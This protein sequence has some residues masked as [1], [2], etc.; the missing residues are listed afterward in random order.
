MSINFKL[1][2]K[3]YNNQINLILAEDGLT[4]RCLLNYG[5]TNKNFCPNCVFDIGLKKSANKYKNNGP[6]FFSEGMICPYCNG[7]GFYGKQNSDQIYLAVLWDYKSWMSPPTNIAYPEGYVQT[8]CH[9]SNVFKIRR[10][11]DITIVLDDNISNP[12]FQLHEEPTP[13]GLGDNNY[14]FCMWKKIGVSS[15]LSKIPQ[16]TQPPEKCYSS[17]EKL[18]LLCNFANLCS[19]AIFDIKLNKDLDF[20]CVSTE[21]FGFDLLCDEINKCFSESKSKELFCSYI[22]KCFSDSSDLALVCN[23][24]N[25]CLSEDSFFIDG[26][27]QGIEN[28]VSENMNK[29]HL[30][31]KNGCS[32]QIQN[33]QLSNNIGCLSNIDKLKLLDN[34]AQKC[35]SFT[36]KLD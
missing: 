7:L 22:N 3:I 19:S 29:V 27:C 34:T 12:V 1:L 6:I 30:M 24:I 9:R 15:E 4:T 18:D 26:L 28:C 20:G 32:S 35:K 25:S 16:T 31:N 36:I 23:N 17:S 2:Q 5:I 10:A 14:L 8:I 13:A 11:K 21:L 33:T